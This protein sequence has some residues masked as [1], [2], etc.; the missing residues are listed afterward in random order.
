MSIPSGVCLCVRQHRHLSSVSSFS[1]SR[2]FLSL[3]ILRSCEILSRTTTIRLWKPIGLSGW[4][5]L[6]YEEASSPK[7][8]TNTRLTSMNNNNN[9]VNMSN[10]NS[11]NNKRICDESNFPVTGLHNNTP[12]TRSSIW[13]VDLLRTA[14]DSADACRRDRVR[15]H[16]TTQQLTMIRITQTDIK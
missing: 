16:S 10:N 1:L 7:T 9:N 12:L 4:L 6:F 15:R 8:P 5:E 14:A 3:P 13:L 11:I 2:F